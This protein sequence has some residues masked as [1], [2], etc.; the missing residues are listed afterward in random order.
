MIKRISYLLALI[1][2]TILPAWPGEGMWIPLEIDSVKLKEMQQNGFMLGPGEIYS[3]YHPSLKDAVVIFGGGC[4]GEVISPEGLVLTNHH[5]GYSRI[6]SHSTV[7]HNYLS[8][9]FWAPTRGEEL[10]NPG[11]T[12]TFLVR[13][14]DVTRLVLAGVD[15]SLS[16][17][18]RNR[19]IL[20][21][22]DMIEKNAQGDSH[23]SIQVKSFYF[24]RSYYLFVYEVFKDVRLVG[25]PPESIGRFGGDTDNWIWPRHSGDFS[26][27]RIYAGKDNLPAEYS[28]DNVPYKPR[29]FLSISL[30]GVR[31]GDFTMVLGYPAHTDEYLTSQGLSLIADKSLPAKI[32]MR[33]IRLDAM[34]DEMKKSPESRLR[35]AAK[36]VS[37]SNSWKKWIGVR[38]GIVR[39]DAVNARKNKEEQFNR[40][41]A[42]PPEKDSEY[43]SLLDKFEQ[44]YDQYEPVFLAYDLGNELMNSIESFSL[45]NTFLSKYYT[46]V[47]SSRAYLNPVIEKL[48]IT[49]LNFFRTGALEIDKQILPELLRI[50]AMN[51]AVRY[52][53]AVYNTIRDQFQ[54][55][56]QAYIDKVFRKSYFTDSIRFKKL[57]KR[58]TRVIHNVLWT[59][60]LAGHYTGSLAIS[61][62]LDLS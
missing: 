20:E 36:Y 27:F 46:L 32:E 2:S 28:P 33:Q 51:T 50:Y 23:Y 29:K 6:Q 43:A 35:Y 59:D 61:L 54:N 55:D 1:F 37:V 42:G 3:H 48:R 12:V 8:D 34:R 44:T 60:P 10:P 47:D 18:E 62:S 5:C 9:G 13:M 14:E 16:E 57:M 41:A 11:L 38:K 52:H 7:E 45:T 25:A 39:S 21:N 26:L 40:W 15:D 56:Y 17:P 4:T 49:G 58:S 24:G 30:E 31:D 22:V 53:P 19:K